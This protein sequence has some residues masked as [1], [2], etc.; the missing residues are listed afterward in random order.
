MNQYY[1]DLKLEQM[2]NELKEAQKTFP[3]GEPA[4]DQEIRF[5]CIHRYNRRMVLRLLQNRYEE[6]KEDYQCCL[7]ESERLVHPACRGYAEMDYGKGLYLHAP[8][9][10]LEH[11]EKALKIFQELGT[12]HRR[13]LDCK[14]EVAYLRC[15]LS[16]GR[17]EDIHWLEA[18]AAELHGAHYEELY[19][20]AK[21]KLAA[22]HMCFGTKDLTQ[23]ENELVEAEYVL[24][25]RPCRRLKMLFANVKYVHYILTGQRDAAARKL[26]I[27]EVLASGLGEDYQIISQYNL[28]NQ[29]PVGASFYATNQVS[30][31]SALIDPRL[32]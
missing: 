1:W 7:R 5:A 9:R 21:L 14:C 11:M 18:A 8:E 17:S 10:A 22:L 6:A 2:E 23:A 25:Y 31:M 15:L 26:K 4:Q 24:P 28:L 3:Y 16:G 30:A 13:G 12:E 32:W 27:N 19:S 20:K 29:F